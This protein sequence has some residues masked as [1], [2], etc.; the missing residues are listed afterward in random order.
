[1][2]IQT[3]T[4]KAKVQS[5][6]SYIVS[7]TTKKYNFVSEDNVLI[8][9]K[10]D[11]GTD[12][13]YIN[14]YKLNGFST[15]D[16]VFYYRLLESYDSIKLGENA[17]TISFEKNGKK[18]KKEEFFYIYEPDT[19]KLADIEASFFT[20]VAVDTPQE[21]KSPPEKTVSPSTKIQTSLT[22]EQIQAFDDALYYNTK[23]EVFEIELVYTLADTRLEKAASS[24]QK[25][26]H[27]AGISVKLS[28]ST[29]AD[30][31]V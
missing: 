27:N 9:G 8:E 31:S 28:G 22:Q 1:M 2:T 12:A 15:G 6:L 29:L 20:P 13:V 4:P 5:T 21:Q 3:P 17:Y 16:D 10:V 25:Q 18:E 24:I 26:L 30:M 19:K 23:G 14:D 7:P 11:E